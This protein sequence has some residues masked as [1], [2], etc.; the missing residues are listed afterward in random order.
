MNTPAIGSFFEMSL[1]ILLLLN[2]TAEIPLDEQ[3]ITAIDFI[4]V[5]AA[6]FDILDE[7]L[8]GYSN[9]RFCEFFTR[10]NIIST[11][12]KNLVLDRYIELQF[13][14]SGY[15]YAITENGKI[16]CN[17]L[18]CNYAEDYVLAVQSVISHFNTNKELMLKEINK[19]TTQSLK[20]GRYE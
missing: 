17:K 18:G 5:Y 9:Y 7:N 16:L 19:R 10:K 13:T 8:H 4:S 11:S 6:D 20:E 14:S 12:I 15:K 1:R 2:E 3:Q